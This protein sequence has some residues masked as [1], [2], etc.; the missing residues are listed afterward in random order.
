MMI[1]GHNTQSV[2]DRYDITNERD[3]EQAAKLLEPSAQ[4][5]V[6]EVQNRHTQFCPLASY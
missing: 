3:L 5:A 6:S 1:S 4:P 2:L